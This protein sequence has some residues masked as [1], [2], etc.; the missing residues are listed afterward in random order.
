MEL[1][2]PASVLG[3]RL[4]TQAML[5]S[6]AGAMFLAVLSVAIAKLGVI[7]ALAGVSV[8]AIIFAL[9]LLPNAASFTAVVILYSNIVVIFA[10]TSL[11]QVIGASSAILLALPVGTQLLIYRQSPRFDR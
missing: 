4:P 3:T 9:C 8:L 6:L 2:R 5:A 1:T 7:L 11:Y 10:G